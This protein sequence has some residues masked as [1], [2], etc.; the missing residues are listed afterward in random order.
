MMFICVII[1]HV[2]SDPDTYIVRIQLK[3][4]VTLFNSSLEVRDDTFLP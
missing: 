3:P 1:V 2:S 4:G